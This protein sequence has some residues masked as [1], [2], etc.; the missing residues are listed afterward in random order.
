MQGR[1][2]AQTVMHV[3]ERSDSGTVD[4]VFRDNVLLLIEV[5][6]VTWDNRKAKLFSVCVP[7]QGKI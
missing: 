4:D 2:D 6:N 7:V 5:H 1:F 3:H